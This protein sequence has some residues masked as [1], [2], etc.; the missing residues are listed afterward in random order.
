[1]EWYSRLNL[2][3]MNHMVKKLLLFLRCRQTSL[4][5]NIPYALEEL[6]KNS[7]HI[8]MIKQCQIIFPVLCFCHL[9]GTA[10]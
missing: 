7:H 6:F 5:L 9:I 4:I 3:I 1:M 10:I 8:R 2:S